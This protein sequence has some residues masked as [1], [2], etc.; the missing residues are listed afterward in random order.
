M[1]IRAYRTPKF[2]N[3]YT[4]SIYTITLLHLGNQRN[5]ERKNGGN[6]FSLKASNE[7]NINEDDCVLGKVLLF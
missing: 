2:I 7:V 4:V 1:R 5:V 6:G 3:A